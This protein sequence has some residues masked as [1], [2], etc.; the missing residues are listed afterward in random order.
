MIKLNVKGHEE[1][2]G[3]YAYS[4]TAS[5]DGRTVKEVLEEIREYA[6]N[7]GNDI[8]EGF[9]KPGKELGAAWE[10]RING[11]IYLTC[12]CGHKP[13]YNH[14]ND[15]DIVEKV[16]VDGGWYCFYDFDIYT[17]GYGNGK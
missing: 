15:N 2:C 7:V 4:G 11:K 17:R 5:F 8:G 13:T 12:W 1:M 14:E 16:K 3:G 6:K 10:I 9:G